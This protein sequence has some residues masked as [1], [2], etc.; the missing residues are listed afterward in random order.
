MN[1]PDFFKFQP[2]NNLRKQLNAKIIE[3]IEVVEINSLT[4]DEIS[5][6]TG[7]GLDISIGDVEVLQD[8]TLAYKNA[9]VVLY[10]RDWTYHKG[11]PKFHVSNCKTLKDMREKGRVA[12]YVV[13][14]RNDG[15]FN[16]NILNKDT[17]NFD[18]KNLELSV[19]KNCLNNINWSE[20]SSKPFNLDIYFQKF[21]KFLIQGNH[22]KDY[23]ALINDYADNWRELSYKLRDENNWKCQ[24]CGKDCINNKNFLHVHHING[25]KNDNSKINLKILCKICHSQEPNHGHLLYS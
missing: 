17:N 20:I 22:K 1:L 8:G 4:E 19:C 18:N 3:D 10:I 12:R 11:F 25:L 15:I 13:A 24:K 16:V 2:F 5:K 21:S 9:R 6:L 14:S 23:E 7:I